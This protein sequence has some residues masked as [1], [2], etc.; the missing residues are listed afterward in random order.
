MKNSEGGEGLARL[1]RLQIMLSP[2]ELN[3]VETF[4]VGAVRNNTGVKSGEYGVLKAPKGLG[5]RRT[6]AQGQS[7]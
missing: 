4:S 1:E 3:A 2:E 5:S 6:S 7:S